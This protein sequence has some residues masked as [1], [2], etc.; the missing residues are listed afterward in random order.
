MGVLSVIRQ[1]FLETIHAREMLS[2]EKT[3]PS[4]KPFYIHDGM[5]SLLQ[6]LGPTHS[7]PTWF[8]TGSMSMNAK[9]IEIAQEFDLQNITLILSGDEWKRPDLSISP[10]MTVFCHLTFLPFQ[11]FHKMMTGN[12]FLWIN[13]ERGT[14]P[15]N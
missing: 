14:T 6:N 5:R 11:I 1:T 9:A 12:K 3:N 4:A 7:S 2:F 10:G 8:E 15:Q 13:S